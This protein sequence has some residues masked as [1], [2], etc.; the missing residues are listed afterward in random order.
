M[1]AGSDPN[2]IGDF[3]LFCCPLSQLAHYGV[4]FTYY[5]Y[6]LLACEIDLLINSDHLMLRGSVLI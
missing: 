5:M 6:L 1:P 3:F 4:D 2:Q